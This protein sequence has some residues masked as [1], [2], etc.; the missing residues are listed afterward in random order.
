[1]L[2]NGSK[3][4]KNHTLDVLGNDSN[5]GFCKL[6]YGDGQKN[7]EGPWLKEKEDQKT[8]SF[9]NL[10]ARINKNVNNYCKFHWLKQPF[11]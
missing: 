4:I 11:F 3:I 2:P 10:I 8:E 5:S 9:E 7:A 6:H 1:M